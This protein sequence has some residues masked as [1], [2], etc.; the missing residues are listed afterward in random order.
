M[1]RHEL[2]KL[3]P[4]EREEETLKLERESELESV[5]QELN[6]FKDD[7]HVQK[8][9][10]DRKDLL[11][12]KI[13]KR[14]DRLPK[15]KGNITMKQHLQNLYEQLDKEPEVVINRIVNRLEERKSSLEVEL[16]ASRS[17]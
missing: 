4:K 14:A 3:T 1:D 7:K 9:I 11:Q 15:H 16:D 10:N 12:E 13:S 2:E 6:L 17:S 8:F 5:N